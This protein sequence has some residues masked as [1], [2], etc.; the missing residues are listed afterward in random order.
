MNNFPRLLI[1]R[2]MASYFW[3]LG[4][5][6]WGIMTFPTNSWKPY[7][8]ATF[9][10]IFLYFYI[11]TLY[12]FDFAFSCI[13]SFKSYIYY[14]YSRYILYLLCLLLSPETY[15]NYH[16]ISSFRLL[17]YHFT[18]RWNLYECYVF[19]RQKYKFLQVD[20]SEECWLEALTSQHII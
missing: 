18:K 17:F 8:G 4:L 6:S 12:S 1:N 7:N 16:A 3:E 13:F 10:C 5:S 9:I 19:C 14:I 15:N 11:Q 2:F 20:I